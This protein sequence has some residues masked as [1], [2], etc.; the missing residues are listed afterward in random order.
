ME[1]EHLHRAVGEGHPPSDD[2]CFYLND[3]YIPAGIL[4]R[5]TEEERRKREME[6]YSL[7]PK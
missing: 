3:L 4:F 5:G 7:S 1:R 6:F 2:T